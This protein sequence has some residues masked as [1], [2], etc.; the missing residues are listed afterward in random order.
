MNLK[1]SI[2]YPSLAIA[3]TT[4]LSTLFLGSFPVAHAMWNGHNPCS[5]SFY[6][7][8][9]RYSPY[10]Y[11]GG[12]G[13]N[14]PC[15]R[16]DGPFD[17][18]NAMFSIP[19]TF[20]TLQ[21]QQEQ[22]VERSIESSTTPQYDI[23]EDD[24]KME[25]ALDLPGVRAEDITVELKNEGKALKI[26]GS[27]SSRNHGRLFSSKFDQMFSLDA[28]TIDVNKID[29]TLSDGVLRVSAPKLKKKNRNRVKRIPIVEKKRGEEKISTILAEK[30]KEELL[31]KET[32]VEETDPLT[33]GL[34]ITEEEDI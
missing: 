18:L 16:R 12:C 8:R 30:S 19:F 28:N 21:R 9:R 14:R 29:V 6:G 15:R 13:I 26:S 25:L 2:L 20:N 23:I 5:S 31:D 7:N 24:T 10:Y 33:D 34:E 22:Q 4:S 32:G 27:R 11:G 3:S 17:L 1:R